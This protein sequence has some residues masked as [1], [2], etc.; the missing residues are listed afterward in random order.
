ML[1]RH[2][3]NIVYI[4]EKNHITQARHDKNDKPEQPPL[5]TPT[6]SSIN[7]ENSLIEDSLY[8]KINDLS[9]EFKLIEDE[10]ERV[11]YW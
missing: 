6:P 2:L 11:K 7:E 10:Q 1:Q 4:S 5:A 8:Q 3:K 9:K